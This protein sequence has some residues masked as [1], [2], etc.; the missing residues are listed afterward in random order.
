MIEDPGTNLIS[1]SGGYG[2]DNRNGSNLGNAPTSSVVDGI[3]LPDGTV[4]Q[5]ED[6]KH[7]LAET[8]V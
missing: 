2:S 5:V 1:G 6:F 4:G 3:T 7:I 8:L